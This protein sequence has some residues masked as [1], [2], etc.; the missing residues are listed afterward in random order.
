M[1]RADHNEKEAKATGRIRKPP[2]GHAWGKAVLTA[3][4]K[5]GMTKEIFFA[6]DLAIERRRADRTL[7]GIAFSEEKRGRLTLSRLRVTSSEG[8][9]SIGKPMGN[10]LTV[11]FPPPEEMDEMEKETFGALL[12]ACYRELGPKKHR[13]RTLFIGLG[14]R[15]M[16]PD[17]I[18]PA[19]AERLHATA[20][21]EKEEPAVFSALHAGALAV[22]SPGVMAQTGLEA[23]AVARAVSDLYRPELVLAADALAA[24]A[25]ER[26]MRTVQISD[27]G[28]SPGSG[29]GNRRLTLD[30]EALGVP[31]IALGVPT[32]VNSATLIAD[33]L[34]E[35]GLTPS[36][37]MQ[38]LLAKKKNFFVS[39]R[40]LDEE[41]SLLADWI[42]QATDRFFGAGLAL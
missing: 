18:G 10:Y 27:T 7:P 8:A 32:V 40:T 11:S 14:N 26:L 20:H 19:V 25:T 33:A 17:A 16:T 13:P 21:L 24:R 6:S 35:S 38:D 9:A 41:L 1:P 2:A 42:A 28:L 30:K 3:E 23:A 22:L 39:P 5:R 12:S 37:E 31:V 34:A 15:E 36:A 4:R 29:V